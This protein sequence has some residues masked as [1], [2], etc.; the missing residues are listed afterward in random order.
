VDDHQLGLA[1]RVRCGRVDVQFAEQAAKA[2]VL[3][4]RQMLVAEEDDEVLGERAVELV[5]GAVA[6]RPRQVDSANL[7]AND[8]GQLVDRDRVIRRR[9]FGDV[10]VSRPAIRTNGIHCAL[11]RFLPTA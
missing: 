10:F 3:I 9:C 2:E 1:G 5:E 6:E 8:R 4:F 11:L 7:G